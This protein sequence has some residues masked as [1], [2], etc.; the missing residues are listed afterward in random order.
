[1]LIA[2]NL[3]ELSL[4]FLPKTDRQTNR[5]R[6]T[7]RQTDRQTD[8]QAD[9]QGDREADREAHANRQPSIKKCEQT[10]KQAHRQTNKA[11]AMSS[12]DAPTPCAREL[13]LLSH[14]ALMAR[15][16]LASRHFCPKVSSRFAT[17][18]GLTQIGYDL[19]VIPK[20]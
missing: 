13:R 12:T 9:R 17:A 1:M 14:H 19:K 5:D 15:S 3:G 8:R 16:N 2:L 20:N 11:K 6:H 10:K 7:A 4:L 18:P